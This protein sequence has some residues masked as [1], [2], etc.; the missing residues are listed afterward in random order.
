MADLKVKITVDGKEEY[1]SVEQLAKSIGRVGSTTR[2]ATKEISEFDKQSSKAIR[3]F[4]EEIFGLESVFKGAVRFFSFGAVIDSVIRAT[5]VFDNMDEAAKKLAD[6]IK[7]LDDAF[8]NLNKTAKNASLETSQSALAKA[9][10]FLKEVVKDTDSQRALK[11]FN[12]I[13]LQIESLN[14]QLVPAGNNFDKLK[15]LISSPQSGT[16][17]GDVVS[18]FR[19]QRGIDPTKQT[20][21]F[22]L[23]QDAN[24]IA[25]QKQVGQLKDAADALQKFILAQENGKKTTDNFTLSIS[26]QVKKLKLSADQILVG[27]DL[28]GIEGLENRLRAEEEAAQLAIDA[29]IEINKLKEEQNEKNK[30]AQE[31]LAQIERDRIDSMVSSAS[32][33]TRILGDALTGQAKNFRQRILQ[34]ARDFAAELISS[35]ALSGISKLFG[36][37]GSFGLFGTLFGGFRANGGDVQ[38]GKSYIVGERGAEMFTPKTNG[39]ISPNKISSTGFDPI[40]SSVPSKQSQQIEVMNNLQLFIDSQQVD[41]SIKRN[42]SRLNTRRGLTG[43]TA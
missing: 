10:E 34:A 38:A 21:G 17:S 33:F 37:G 23:S 36:G 9:Q 18:F 13:T 39:Y 29:Q 42:G 12:D 27:A 35:M 32:Q 41:A 4:R 1:V 43:A 11:L 7:S 30:A 26:E 5:G 6:G 20:Q 19:S 2:G 3:K 24:R 25:I 8:F 15:K 28:A 40:A 16:V 31:E 14:A 22:S